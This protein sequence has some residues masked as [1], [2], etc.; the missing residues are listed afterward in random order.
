M[1]QTVGAVDLGDPAPDVRDFL[2]LLEKGPVL[3]VRDGL[4]ERVMGRFVGASRHG[5]FSTVV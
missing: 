5:K 4:F 1:D 3:I 2:G